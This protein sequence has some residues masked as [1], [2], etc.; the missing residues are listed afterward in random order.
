MIT[1][2]HAGQVF[3]LDYSGMGLQ[4]P[5]MVKDRLVVVVS[6]RA[7]N[8]KRGLATVIPLSTTAPWERE[9]HVVPVSKDYDWV[10][11]APT[12]W[13]KADMIYTPSL[14]RLE[15]VDRVKNR[16]AER[17]N[18]NPVPQVSKADLKNIRL[19]IAHAVGLE[20]FIVYEEVRGFTAFM[21]ERYRALL[22][23]VGKRR[24]K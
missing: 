20:E 4:V 18:Y 7:L 3:K 21:T 19:G 15:Y 17:A 11:G 13:A 23:R 6:P 2:C 14:N 5:E 22:K 10:K 16:K 9:N 1:E 24:R 8:V 12:L